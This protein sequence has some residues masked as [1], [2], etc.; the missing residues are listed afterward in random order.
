[1]KK[2]NITLLNKTLIDINIYIFLVISTPQGADAEIIVS[3]VNVVGKK[4]SAMTLQYQQ[5][6]DSN[7][8]SQSVLLC[9][10]AVNNK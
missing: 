4:I 3:R 2:C 6:G 9:E 5:E 7:D 1:M 8:S 10:T